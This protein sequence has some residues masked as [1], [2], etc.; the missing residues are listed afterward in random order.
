MAR[1]IPP[2]IL[3]LLL[4]SAAAAPARAEYFTV[5]SFAAE[6]SVGEHGDLVVREEIV[7][8]FSSPRHGIYRD[9]PFLYTDSLGG[10]VRTPLEILSV[11]NGAGE[12]RR[13]KVVR[14]KSDLR[15]R[16]GHPRVY[17]DGRQLYVIS[18]RVRN[19]LLRLSDR[20]ELAWNVTGSDWGAPMEEV[21]STV[22]LPAGAEGS[23]LDVRCYTGVRG[24]RAADCGAERGE[25]RV[26]FAAT[27]PLSPNEELT[28][29]VGWRKGVVGEP[30]F[31]SRLLLALNARE[32]WVFL[33]PLL[34]LG[35]YLAQWSR[36]GRDPSTGSVAV[37]FGPPT[38][39]GS[40]IT[41]AEAGGLVDERFDPRDLAAAVIGL[42]V[43]G[44]LTVEERGTEG[45][46]FSKPD[47]YL[48][49]VKPAGEGLTAFEST[50]MKRLFPG[51]RT[52]VQVSELKNSFYSHLDGLR[53]S[54]F[55]GLVDRGY[56]RTRPGTVR[57]WYRSAALVL[58]LAG[59]FAGMFAGSLFYSTSQTKNLVAFLVPGAVLLLLARHMPAKT[60]RGAWAAAEVRGFEEFL[61]RAEKD[62]LERMK[63]LNLFEKFLP[64][65]IALD[66]SERWAAA[67][68]GLHQEPPRWYVGSSGWDGGFR[69]ASFNESLG[70][71]LSSMRT[72]MYTAP[73]SSGGG[74]S[75]SSGGGF[76]GGGFGGGGG[77]SW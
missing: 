41:P 55:Q 36:A 54:L 65:A 6:V 44:Y 15:V 7:V 50:L 16:I 19:A 34:F 17:V 31:P 40:E 47:Y 70:S 71:A 62:R 22:I 38:Q 23:I 43:R 52:G 49:R 9:L 51:D 25:R 26:R 13:Y 74:G 48:R 29:A 27:R 63:D 53:D 4:F 33:V 61:S 11:L 68:E 32:N 45:L 75:F 69:P 21:S 14:G 64:Y 20:D 24:S 58:L 8:D 60:R 5:R 30:S 18:Y 37:M 28:V 59:F 67:F 1:R 10:K 42:A 56:F 35:G 66:V 77:G 2:G 46:L 57:M 39:G 3:L 73:R 12:E 72:S 76:S